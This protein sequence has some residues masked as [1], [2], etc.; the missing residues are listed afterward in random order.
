MGSIPLSSIIKE[1]E[2]GGAGLILTFLTKTV[3][4][5]CG[6]T[7]GKKNANL[8]LNPTLFFYWDSQIIQ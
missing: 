3:L 4:K 8:T 1:E 6:L 5:K 7:V 2:K